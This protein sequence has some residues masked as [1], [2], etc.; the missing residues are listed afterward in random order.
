MKK[1]ILVFLIICSYLLLI[2]GAASAGGKVSE[3][4]LTVGKEQAL[5]DNQKVMMDVAPIIEN[6][7]TLVP[8]RFIGE[9]FGTTVDWK[10]D[11]KQ[12][13]LRYG[14]ETT[15]LWIGKNSA[16]INGQAR[17]LDAPPQVFKD[18]TLVPLRFISE[19][20]GYQ[21]DYQNK[22]KVITI[23]RP[24][25]PPQANFTVDKKF[26]S[27][28]EAV[29]Y[30]DLSFDP[31]GDPIVDRIWMNNNKRFQIPGVYVVSLKVK[32]SRGAW[33]EWFE[34]VVEVS[35]EPNKK[36]VARFFPD[37]YKV[38]VDQPI[39]YTDESYDPDGDEI[40]EWNWQNRKESFSQPG[41]YYVSLQVKDRRDAW[42][43]KCVQV[44]EVVEKPNEPP[45]A[46]F[47][48]EKTRVAQG[49]TVIFTDESMDPDGD[50]L[51]EF[52]WTGKQRAYFKEGTYPVTLKVKDSRGKW[53]EPF[54]VEIQVTEKV[55]MNEMEYNLHNP[56][57][58]E[59]VNL[60][61]IKP[62]SFP[63]LKPASQNYDNTALLISNSPETVKEN[64]ILYRDTIGG[65]LRLMYHH[66]NGTNTKKKVYIL[67]GNPGEQTARITINKK[68]FGGPSLD[69]LAI[70]RNGLARF[71]ES[72]CHE[73][74]TLEPGQVIVLE[75]VGAAK[76]IAPEHSVF[77][78]MDLHTTADI[79]FTFVMVDVGT[80]VLTAFAEL[81]VLERDMH[82]RGT[83]FGVNRV[84]RLEV[85]GEQ[86]VRFS[87]ADNNSDYHLGGVDAIT[88]EQVINKGNYGLMYRLKVKAV[89]RMG[90]LTNPRGGL[91][92]GATMTEDGTVYGV[93][94][95]GHRFIKD[96]SQA[97]MN[98][99]LNP[100]EETELI[101][102]PPV[103]STM[104]VMFLFIPF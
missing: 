95:N 56:L 37:N 51:V 91:F 4:S 96:S 52:Q 85:E 41:I 5:L 47:S 87:L 33:S 46:R 29:Y 93:P 31:D 63:V 104:P 21:V 61:D 102:M 2:S 80:D 30:Q 13:T 71:L 42:S 76:E 35:A 23:K 81:P 49:E 74:Y 59:I 50:Q 70:G 3:I 53:S 60:T 99:V 9:A 38:Y 45:V 10:P 18:R 44:I 17:A 73:Q 69:D 92:M 82:Q 67:A 64:G 40:V 86:P 88:G 11:N 65:S 84:Y 1:S 27:V 22:T 89:N 100:G 20:F 32:D 54:T 14:Q 19:A 36:P 34:Q 24:N 12:I 78:M 16:E 97:V 103:S 43:D 66:K 58:G 98:L 39:I 8:L 25:T 6:G 48:V 55:L 62:L 75:G 15:K 28:G 72:N 94:D 83:F 57:A 7:R 101:F 90:I 68:G 77:S 26:V 79:T